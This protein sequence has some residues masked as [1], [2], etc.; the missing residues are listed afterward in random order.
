M[1]SHCIKL[2]AKDEKNGIAVNAKKPII[3]GEI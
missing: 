3:Q 2:R 1:I